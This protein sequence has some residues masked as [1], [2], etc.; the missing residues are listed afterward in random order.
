MKRQLTR[1]EQAIGYF[2]G[3]LS[4]CEQSVV[5]ERFFADETY[6]RFLDSMEDD[7]IDDYIYGRL[8]FKQ[9]QDFEGKYLV[10][11]RRRDKVSWAQILQARNIAEK[12]TFDFTIAANHSFW[13]RLENLFPV[14]TSSIASSLSAITFLI[15]L[16]GL[17]LASSAE[18]HKTAK[19]ENEVQ[20]P[21]TEESNQILSLI[22]PPD[23]IL[24]SPNL[25]QKLTVK[26]W[27]L[28]PSTKPNLEKP[29]INLSVKP[30]SNL[31]PDVLSPAPNPEKLS[32]IDSGDTKNIHLSVAHRESQAFVSYRVEIHAA[33]GDLLWSREIA[34]NKRKLHNQLPLSVRRGAL[35]GSNNYGLTI[36]GATHD[37]QLEEISFYNFSIQKK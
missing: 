20:T 16:G 12:E 18:N 10:S 5:E 26:S 34:A 36:S 7:L 9:T 25:N 15:L 2:L 17:W 24:R 30:K 32:I 31:P 27:R 21:I 19:I 14:L 8:D 37:G 6:S 29:R 4:E 33:D 28:K 3:A 35:V 1:K 23:E 11:Q 22:V 13:Q